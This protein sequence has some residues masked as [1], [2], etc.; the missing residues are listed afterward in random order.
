MKGINEQP[1]RH[2]TQWPHAKIFCTKT[3]VTPP[4]E[5]KIMV[6]ID[7]N[8]VL[9]AVEG[10]FGSLPLP[11]REAIAKPLRDVE[12][13]ALLD[14]FAGR[15]WRDLPRERVCYHREMLGFMT[16]IGFQ[17]YFPAWLVHALDDLAIQEYTMY[18]LCPAPDPILRA[19]FNRL[20]P[21]LDS[22]QRAAIRLWLEYL[23]DTPGST[24]DY[25]REEAGRAI[26]QF[27][28]GDRS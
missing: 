9:K 10:A 5:S 23:R 25:T 26:E 16:P 3:N 4:P 19:S 24:D 11:A 12:V 21:I 13:I 20:T 27:C 6:N 14:D 7:R 18:Q 22:S 17:F 1:A 8:Q 2:G 15:H 28:W